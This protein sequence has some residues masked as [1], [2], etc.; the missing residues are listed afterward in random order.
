MPSVH[1]MPFTHMEMQMRIEVVKMLSKKPMNTAQVHKELRKVFHQH[2][3]STT[4]RLLFKLAA[5]ELRRGSG[6]FIDFKRGPNPVEIV[7]F[8]RP[9]H[10]A[11]YA[12][13]HKR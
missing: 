12:I 9:R 4:A 13:R 3:Y 5:V 11:E 1:D 8:L 6:A 10:E 2:H 7:W